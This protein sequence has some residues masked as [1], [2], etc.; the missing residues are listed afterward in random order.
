MV[1]IVIVSHSQELAS[2]VRDLALQM[3]R[4]RHVAIAAAGGL[5]DGTLGTSYD[6]IEQ[7]VREALS[8][9]GVLVLMDLGSAVMT[10]QMVV[11]MLEPEERTRVRLCS[12]PLVEGAIAAAAAAAAGQSLD[13]VQRAAERVLADAP[14]LQVDQIESDRKKPPRK[15]DVLSEPPG[16][17]VSAEIAVPNPMGLHARPAMQLVETACRF[18]SRITLS[19]LSRKSAP[20]NAKLPMQVAFGA[21]AR[22]GERIR[23]EAAGADAEAAV[24][25][26]RGLVESGFGEMDAAADVQPSPDRSLPESMTIPLRPPDG[27]M[28]G[29]GVSEGYAVGPAFVQLPDTSM[30]KPVPPADPDAPEKEAVRLHHAIGEARSR[31]ER[32]QARV[33]GETDRNT[34]RIFAFQRML[35][36][37]AQVVGQ[38][39]SAI[40][41]G[42]SPAETA[43]RAVFAEWKA[44]AARLDETMRARMVDLADVES[45]LLRILGGNRQADRIHLTKPA[46]VVAADLTP[47]DVARLDRT[48]VKGI[49]TAAGGAG[50]HTAILARSWGIP[51]VA[52]LGEAVLAIPDGTMIALDG[53]AGVFE[54]NPPESVAEAFRRRADRMAAFRAE[55]MAS[56]NRPAATRDGKSVS[57]L[58]NAGDTDS[59]RHAL[60]AGADG[61]GLLRTEFLFL[62]R[63]AMPGEDEQYAVYR[64]IAEMAHPKPVVMRT[65]DAG[66]D[67]PLPGAAMGAGHDPALG[68][69][70]LR[71]CLKRPA[72]FQ[73]QLRAMLRA[74]VAGN[75]K[76]MF[77]MIATRRELNQA[78]SALSAAGESL[79]RDGLAHAKAVAV[80][81]MVETP[82]AA[83][84]ADILAREVDFLSIGTNDLTQYTLACERGNPELAALFDPW[85]TGVL[86]LIRRT[87]ECA[88]A[89]G[90]PVSVCGELAGQERAIPLLLGFGLDTFSV[91][92]ARLPAVKQWIRQQD[93][94]ACIEAAE[95]SVHRLT[96]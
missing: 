31:L 64:E 15:R 37:D 56:A 25:A 28:Q 94:T 21:T 93:R 85:D 95:K 68:V 17:L 73:V 62:N 63:S 8:Q 78:L 39:E 29:I 72:L 65:L 12:A 4:E 47:S 70:G 61:I 36:E 7:A 32:L 71:W 80:G 41:S 1:G 11:E 57:V 19:N 81:I 51:A 52:G 84:S 50:S 82:A 34:G 13:D 9:E 79:A 30:G 89:A 16:P 10:T 18:R 46:I 44:R 58:A 77:P 5:E 35:L 42:R 38:M 92:P 20:V 74:A 14:K 59:V 54:A 91:A 3:C 45:R 86:R 40:R 87:I 88:R 48:R 53:A 23:I 69:R 33:E 76:I 90:R 43:V 2:G 60:G 75:V 22:Q 49:A 55:A 26:L 27:R 67:K 66:G 24:A 6:R 83:V 96:I